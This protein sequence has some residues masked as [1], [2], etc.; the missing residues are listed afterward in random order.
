MK[1]FKNRLVIS[2]SAFLFAWGIGQTALS[3]DYVVYSVDRAI[4][5]GVPGQEP[6]K[7]FYVNLGSDNGAAVGSILE[8]ARRAPT[9]DLAASKLYKESTFI[10]AHLRII[11]SEG[12]ISIAR[13]EKMLPADKIPSIQ[14]FMVMVGDLVRL[15]QN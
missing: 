5:L 11:H 15:K 13:L 1:T 2:A 7:D 12:G 4:D 3:A 10:I 9:Y 6:K 14:P 8:V